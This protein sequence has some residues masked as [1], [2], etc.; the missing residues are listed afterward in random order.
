[1]DYNRREMGTSDRGTS[2]TRLIIYCTTFFENF[3]GVRLRSVAEKV[4]RS[5]PY[6]CLMDLALRPHL[7]FGHPAG[8]RRRRRDA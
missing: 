1:M 3:A 4:S 2:C 7:P 5:Q 8:D 6:P